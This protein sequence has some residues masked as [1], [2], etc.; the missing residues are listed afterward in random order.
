MCIPGNAAYI[1]DDLMHG[2]GDEDGVRKSGARGSRETHRGVPRQQGFTSTVLDEKPCSHPQTK[3]T[4]SCDDKWWFLQRNRKSVAEDLGL[5]WL[6]SF[7]DQLKWWT[8]P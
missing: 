7:S 8:F 1:D 5:P 6:A 2:V 4:C 3:A